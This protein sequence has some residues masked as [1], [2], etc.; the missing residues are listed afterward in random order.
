MNAD[1]GS[2]E[3]LLEHRHDRD[4]TVP[5]P[6]VVELPVYGKSRFHAAL[7]SA[8]RRHGFNQL[9]PGLLLLAGGA[10]FLVAVWGAPLLTV[11]CLFLIAGTGLN[12]V[13]VARGQA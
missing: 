9:L 8:Q 10:C 13:R 3:A 1:K 12:L 7:R 2:F 5:Y 6:R 11:G 4:R